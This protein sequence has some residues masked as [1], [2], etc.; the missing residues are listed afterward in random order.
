MIAARMGTLVA[1]LL[2]TTGVM[3]QEPD[4]A[5]KTSALKRAY[6]LNDNSMVRWGSIDL[7]KGEPSAFAFLPVPPVPRVPDLD[8]RPQLMPVIGSE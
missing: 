7:S 3:A 6:R 2:M 1:V 4:Q 8:Q 5:A